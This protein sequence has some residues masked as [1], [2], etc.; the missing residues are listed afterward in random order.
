[1][2]TTYYKIMTIPMQHGVSPTDPSPHMRTLAGRNRPVMPSH[3]APSS[4]AVASAHWMWN[5]DTRQ[6]MHVGVMPTHASITTYR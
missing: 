2:M 1:M 5:L 6:V 4:A 3:H